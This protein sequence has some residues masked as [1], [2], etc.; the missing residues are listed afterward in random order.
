M[1]AKN[2]ATT[3]K[4]N[5]AIAEQLAGFF[6]DFWQKQNLQTI[7]GTESEQSK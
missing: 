2:Q 7:K 6:F 4:Q 3:E 1:S 5:A